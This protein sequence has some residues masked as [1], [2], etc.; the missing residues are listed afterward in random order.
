MTIVC[1]RISI[2]L[3]L[4]VDIVYSIRRLLNMGSTD[5]SAST[6]VI[7]ILSASSGYHDFRSSCRTVSGQGK[8]EDGGSKY[9]EEVVQLSAELNTGG[10]TADDDNVQQALDFLLRLSVEGR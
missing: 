4:N 1:V 8:D 6:S 9:L 3:S 2:L 5:G 10:A 7:L